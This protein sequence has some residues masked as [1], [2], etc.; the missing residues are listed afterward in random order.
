MTLVSVQVS[1]LFLVDVKRHSLYVSLTV[2]GRTVWLQWWPRPVIDIDSNGAIRF[3]KFLT[4]G[5]R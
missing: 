1:R 2:C 5:A 4:V 3:R